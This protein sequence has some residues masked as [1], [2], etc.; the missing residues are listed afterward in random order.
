MSH[1]SLHCLQLSIL[2]C[3]RHNPGYPNSTYINQ[4]IF[5]SAGAFKWNLS[6]DYLH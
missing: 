3:T 1:L 5:K 2:G 6:A 4:Y